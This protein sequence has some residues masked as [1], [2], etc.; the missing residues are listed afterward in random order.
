MRSGDSLHSHQWAHTPWAPEPP[1]PPE[2]L[3]SYLLSPYSQADHQRPSPPI[4][5]APV[6]LNLPSP[7]WRSC[8]ERPGRQTTVARA[9]VGTAYPVSTRAWL[10]CTSKSIRRSGAC[11]AYVHV[12]G[13]RGCACPWRGVGAHTWHGGS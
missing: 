3:D 2:S 10:C 4:S 5:P 8:L 13:V 6:L 9:A 1:R 7:P 12:H 11:S